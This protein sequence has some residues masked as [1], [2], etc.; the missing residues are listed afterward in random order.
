MKIKLLVL[1]VLVSIQAN[2]QT[3]ILRND[4]VR[5]TVNTNG[6]F[7]VDSIM[8]LPVR[9]TVKPSWWNNTKTFNGAFQIG[10]DGKPY[11]YFN[12]A[13]QF[14]SGSGGGGTVTALNQGYGIL[15]TPNPIVSTG[16]Q[17]VDTSVISTKANVVA[18]TANKVN[19]TDTAT[20][21]ANY[22]NTA[23]IGV[24]VQA[25]NANTTLLGNSTTGT[26]NIVR[27][28]SPALI[29]PSI[30]AV[31]VIGGILSFPTGS[32][33]TLM[34]LSDTSTLSNRINT[35]LNITDTA[36][37]RLRAIAG[38]NMSIT[39]TYP[40][41]TFAS[42]GGGG[43]ADSITFATNYRVDTAKA[44]LRTS[45]NAKLNI[46]DTSTMLANYLRKGDTAS[47]SNRIDLKANIASPTFTGT[48]T[49]PT[50]A[51]ITTPNILGLTSGT[52]NDSLVVA[53]PSTG[54]LKRISSARIGGG[55]WA[56]K[57]NAISSG[58]FIGGTSATTNPLIFK[59]NGLN[60]G[61]IN[62]ANTSYGT[63]AY[64]GTSNGTFM[65]YN[66][67]RSNA[68][69]QNT[70]I[71]YE[72]LKSNIV[73]ANNVVAGHQALNG[74]TNVNGWVVAG[75][76]AAPSATGNNGIAIGSD[77]G[78][79]I[80]SGNKNLVVAFQGT[81][82]SPTASN[83]LNIGNVLWGSGCSATGTTAAGSLSVGV[84]APDASAI[85]DLT[86]TTQGFLPPRM[87]GTQAA[88]IASKAEGLMVYVTDTSGG[89]AAK[90]W[91][92]WNGA[93]WEK[94]NP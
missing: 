82:P 88:A 71:G 66:A 62:G 92:G 32:S 45:I 68:Q 1:A 37:I 17:R 65:G 83:Q 10:L 76:Q 63:G 44:N 4:G 90:G 61:Y 54:A 51:N 43:S 81:V 50:G 84:T 42:S 2:A 24:S 13:W 69:V 39:G 25:Y 18:L 94:L 9:D 67:G 27:E 20:M 28:N 87:T 73:G 64:S 19:Y 70:A 80:S 7:A 36:N 35:K 79:S 41:L 46:S 3:W 15:N 59:W 74:G 89:F 8:R 33:G 86:S 72:A 22:L 60:S 58:D 91:Y 47:L 75:F 12:N 16:S 55:G 30:S 38:A 5:T 23:D 14:F 26:G 40:N 53:D 6:S 57:G 49:I 31:N 34:R 52:T 93:A 78:Y 56:L 29:L 21:L 11:Y 48:V 85:L 77:A